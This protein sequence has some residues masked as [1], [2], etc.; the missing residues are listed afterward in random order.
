MGNQLD[1]NCYLNLKPSQ[2]LF[3]SPEFIFAKMDHS[4]DYMADHP[5]SGKNIYEGYII[6]TRLNYQFS[7]EWF[8]RLIVQYNDFADGTLNIEPMLTYQINPFTVFYVGMNQSHGPWDYETSPGSGI[9]T[10]KSTELSSQQFFAKF[11]Y[12]FR[13]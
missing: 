10:D 12:L 6:R 13:M 11:Q 4:A 9:R 3:I 7:R 2:R 8:L 1:F 5:D